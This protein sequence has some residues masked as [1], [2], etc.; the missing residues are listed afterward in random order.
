MAYRDGRKH[1]ARGH[2]STETCDW[3]AA[4]SRPVAAMAIALATMGCS[5]PPQWLDVFGAS[6]IDPPP[7]EGRPFPNLA[8][9][10]TPR[11][12]RPNAARRADAAGLVADRD[13]ARSI[14]AQIRP[15]SASAATAAAPP[16]RPP[17]VAVDFSPGEPRLTS[18]ARDLIATAA[19]HAQTAAGPV[20]VAGETVRARLVAGELQRLG[21]SAS[22]ITIEER[23]GAGPVE[24]FVDS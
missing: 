3:F 11:P 4:R 19:R 16:A 10:P 8:S 22:R 21:V 17:L 15:P 14:E 5:E 7:A 12:E 2:D 6:R 18:Q 20:R 23:P 1:R 24:I 13:A 9:V